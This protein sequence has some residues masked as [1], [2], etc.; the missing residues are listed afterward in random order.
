M[1]GAVRAGDD[2]GSGGKFVIAVDGPD[3]R[4]GFEVEGVEFMVTGADEDAAI[5]DGGCGLDGITCFMFP[6]KFA[7]FDT[8]KSNPQ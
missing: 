2:D 7:G 1:G 4:A 8:V 5:G 3:F 6:A